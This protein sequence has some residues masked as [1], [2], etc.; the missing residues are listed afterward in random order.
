MEDSSLKVIEL[1]DETVFG[2]SENV[3]HSSSPVKSRNVDVNDL[4][5]DTIDAIRA[6]LHKK[7]LEGVVHQQGQVI[8][9]GKESLNKKCTKFYLPL[10]KNGLNGSTLEVSFLQPTSLINLELSINFCNEQRNKTTSLDSEKALVKNLID[11]FGGSNQDRISKKTSFQ[12]EES[13]GDNVE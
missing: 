11:K 5:E 2:Q 3:H 1:Q 7:P 4:G 10:D 12:V 6:V 13:S 8:Q 9:S